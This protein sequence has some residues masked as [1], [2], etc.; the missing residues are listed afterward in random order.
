MTNFRLEITRLFKK[1]SLQKA[2]EKND[3]LKQFEASEKGKKLAAAKEKR[4]M[5]DLERWRVS[6]K[7]FERAKK[8]R[9]V[10]ERLKK[11]HDL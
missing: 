6:R 8:I 9:E 1:T 5:T 11:E 10:Y 2:L 4:E 7:R 3:I